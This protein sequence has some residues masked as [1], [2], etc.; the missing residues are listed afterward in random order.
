MSVARTLG[1]CLLFV[2]GAISCEAEAYDV[3]KNLSYD[4]T[5]G[6]YGTFDFYE[7]KSDSGRANRPAILAIHGGAWK[8]GDRSWGE[9]FAEELCPFGYVVFSINY[10]LSSRPDGTWPALSRLS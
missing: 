5:I 6:F 2:L 7:P 8:G 3:T 1:P 10:R 9:T 4:S